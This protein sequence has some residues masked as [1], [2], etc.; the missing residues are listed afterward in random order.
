MLSARD[1]S[2]LAGIL[3][4]AT[5]ALIIATLISLTGRWLWAGEMLVNFRTHFAWCF[6]LA[7]VAALAIRRWRIAGIAVIGI[8]LNV[9]PMY[10][11]FFAPVPQPLANARAVRVVS[12]NVNVRN[13]GLADIAT[14]LDS[15]GADVVVLV[16]LTPT[17]WAEQLA[18]LLPKLPHR[19][20]AENDGLWGVAILSRWPLVAPRVATRDGVSIAARADVDLGDRTFR[21]YG[22]HLV[23]P[24][25]PGTAR[26]RNAQLAAL[27]REL[28]GCEHACV[29]VGD[30]NVTPWSSHF[31]DVLNSPGVRDCAAGRGFLATWASRLPAFLRIRIDQ[32][33]VAGTVGVADARVGASVGSDHFAT[34]YDLAIAA[35]VAPVTRRH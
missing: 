32:C 14:Y 22:A 4:R 27:G 2:L 21:L 8:A 34:I 13:E 19:Y 1:T 6:L 26:F 15:L 5:G 7:L 10:G 33:L 31:R 11:A 3:G 12:F 23:W 28:A 16:E 18:G 9:W 20:V 25:M 29:A 35:P 17:E 30:F 24:M